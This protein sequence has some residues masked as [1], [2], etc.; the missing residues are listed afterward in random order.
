MSF[1]EGPPEE[2]NDSYSSSAGRTNRTPPPVGGKSSKWQPLTAV[3]PSPVGDNDPFSLGDSDDE[4]DTKNKPSEEAKSKTATSEE[5]I[6]SGSKSGDETK[7]KSAG[8]S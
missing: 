8:S 3:E 5:E 7:S 4:K 2:I 6:G 1:Q